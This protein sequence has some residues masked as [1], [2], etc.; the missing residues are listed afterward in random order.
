VGIIAGVPTFLTKR[1]WL[2]LGLLLVASCGK[3]EHHNPMAPLVDATRVS[4]IV[5]RS[6]RD[7]NG[8]IYVLN[9]DSTNPVRLTHNPAAED[10][11]AWSPDGSKIAFVSSRDGNAEI[12]VM[13]SDSTNPVR[14]TD[15]PATDGHP[16]WSPDGSKI[17]FVRE[18]N[19]HSQI[20]VMSANGA[21]TTN[22][23]NNAAEDEWP[24]WSPDGAKI[25]FQSDRLG[26]TDIY[27]MNADGTNQVAL[28][29]SRGWESP[30]ALAPRVLIFT[31]TCPDWSPDGS[32]IAFVTTGSSAVISIL[33][34]HG[35]QPTMLNQGQSY[36]TDSDPAWSPD[37]KRIA[38]TSYRDGNAEIYVM[39][40]DGT[41]Q[42]RLTNNPA[43]DDAP[44]WA[45]IK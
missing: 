37:G 15:D 29:Y 18:R 20:Y 4:S 36:T 26:S 12:Y 35:G 32:K 38:F 31:A 5:F 25:A 8:E 21:D 9:P 16:A 17:A 6:T 1:L 44:R 3:S 13:N 28:T 24:T 10:R 11:P 42:T 39:H 33:S 27:V 30:T 41:Y 2:C 45:P 34:E 40:A 22:I 14:L 19:G 23:S 43:I 7:G